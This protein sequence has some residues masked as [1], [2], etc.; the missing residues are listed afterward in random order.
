[1]TVKEEV[2]IGTV[3]GTL[4]AIDE[5]IGDNA[6]IDYS[7]TSGN[8]FGLVKLERTN[9]SKAVIVAV[10]RLDREAISK[11]LLTLKCFKFDTKPRLNKAYNRLVSII[12]I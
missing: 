2:P 5:D 8:E 3:I 1:M 11:I 9:D 4:Q 12:I 7:I 6:A 10:A